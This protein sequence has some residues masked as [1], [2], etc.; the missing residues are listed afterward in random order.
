MPNNLF[1]LIM[2]TVA[3]FKKWDKSPHESL[4]Q[5]IVWISLQKSLK[6]EQ[7]QNGRD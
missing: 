1:I 4:K 7:A 3:R 2:D 5:R 6:N